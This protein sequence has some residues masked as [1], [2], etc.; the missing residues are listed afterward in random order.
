[1]MLCLLAPCAAGAQSLPVASD[2]EN[3][4]RA[5][6]DEDNNRTIL[7]HHRRANAEDDRLR[8]VTSLAGRLI[9]GTMTASGG[10][11]WLF[12]DD[13]AVQRVDARKADNAWGVRFESTLLP[14]LR[15]EVIP[16]ATAASQGRAWV[17]VRV[18]DAEILRELD[19]SVQRVEARETIS[20]SASSE[21]ARRIALGLPPEPA[22]PGNANTSEAST[23]DNADSQPS[24]RD[25]N[26]AEQQEPRATS[27]Q[28]SSGQDATEPSASEADS[29][30]PASRP[31]LPQ[32][33]L[34]VE[35]GSRWEV[36]P[37]PA[38]WPHLAW[39]DVVFDKPD[40]AQPT[41]VAAAEKVVRVFR[42][43]DGAW[44]VQEV[45]DEDVA[46]YRRAIGVE[47]Q[48]VLA[49]LAQPG[50]GAGD[51]LTLEL[52]IVR[53]DRVTDF[54]A[55]LEGHASHPWRVDPWGGG[56]GVFASPRESDAVP[57]Q[58][59]PS[60]AT[61][62]FGQQPQPATATPVTL[63][64][65]SLRGETLSPAK[66]LTPT[67]VSP[68]EGRADYMLLIGVMLTAVT[69]TLMSWRQ[70]ARFEQLDI[71]GAQPADLLRRFLAAAVDLA[72]P[73]LIVM[74]VF[75]LGPTELSERW[76]PQPDGL[77][78][79]QM[80][81]AGCLVGLFLLHTIVSEAITGRTLGKK[82]LGLAVVDYRGDTPSP[83]RVLG[84]GVLKV[85]D[86]VLW[87]LIILAIVTPAR[88]RLGDLVASTL[89][90][91]PRKDEP[92]DAS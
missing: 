68:W 31:D 60:P 43:R 39:V 84:R 36:R 82:L 81:P 47:S 13:G 24:Q 63:K 4:W 38:A 27:E 77:T 34:L 50:G 55:S 58:G 20:R 14:P 29:Q 86:L 92:E 1:M 80:I 2:G 89:V 75:N 51:A 5:A 17:I 16:M 48:L 49:R 19:A 40:A 83:A 3:L 35:S 25:R 53:S 88:Q 23:P 37:L 28:E 15:R 8:R 22:S 78:W 6:Y 90:V 67:E 18:E 12:F 66:T 64:S 73:G 74:A 52:R 76:P 32:H 30:K 46:S 11:L 42:H 10:G 61:T 9:P 65:V 44:E 72:V 26:Q 59:E 45:E 70:A 87:M 56:V 21:R 71:E 41:L 79:G 62:P 7:Y 54:R 69:L 57:T 33:R 85:L 91:M